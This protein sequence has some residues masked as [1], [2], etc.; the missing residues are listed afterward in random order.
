MEKLSILYYFYGHGESLC[1]RLPGGLVLPFFEHLCLNGQA[2]GRGIC[3]LALPQKAGENGRMLL[4]SD[5]F[6]T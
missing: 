6:T 1:K 4:A 3:M 5:V 2:Q